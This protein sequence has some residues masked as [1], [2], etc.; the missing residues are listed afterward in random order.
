MG[1]FRAFGRRFGA[2]CSATWR[3]SVRP[4][5]LVRT[6]SGRLASASS[7][8]AEDAPGP[9]SSARAMAPE[10]RRRRLAFVILVAVS[11][12][13]L[14]GTAAAGTASVNKEIHGTN[15]TPV[16]ATNS[17][18]GTVSSSTYTCPV[19]VTGATATNV[20]TPTGLS[21]SAT[22]DNTTAIQKAINT[23]GKDGGGVVTLPAGTF[24]INGHLVMQNNVELTG[25]GTGQNGTTLVAGPKFLK[26]TGTGGG[27]PIIS[28]AGADNVTIASLIANQSGNTLNANVPT[29]LFSYVVEAR[30]STNVLFS[31]VSVI[32][33]FTYSI[34][35]VAS[36]NFCVENSS[37]NASATETKYDQLDGIHIMDSNNGDVINNTIT[38]GDDALA[39]HT[40][41]A[42][43]YN[44][45]FANNILHGGTGAS[46]LQFA[47]QSPYAIYNITA[48][49]NDVTGSGI[50]MHT[51]YYGS[52]A[53]G[54][55]Y[56]IQILNN[57]IYDLLNGNSG[58][59]IQMGDSGQ[60]GTVTQ[61]TVSNTLLC[62][63]G[64][65]EVQSGSGNTVTGTTT[66]TS[67]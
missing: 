30:A 51:G 49:N 11:T 13:S 57:Y 42:P 5:G 34:A 2:I 62:N 35:M 56:G 32:N 64:S 67:C 7:C 46:G 23:A 27:Y 20:I 25:A 53:T 28:T 9:V 4:P 52:T 55:V 1:R 31:N 6:H 59:S 16:H 40:M 63:A 15:S 54:D 66:T 39:A 44:V 50:G 26:T 43:V 12:M 22:V 60:V 14:T 29:R 48:E 61:I 41:G 24:M 19:S 21:T 45:V 18:S 8:L 10:R 47:V 37:V 58:L 17:T 38:S 36:S 65:I 3:V 33:P